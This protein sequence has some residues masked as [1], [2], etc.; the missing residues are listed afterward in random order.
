MVAR[1]QATIQVNDADQGWLQDN[2]KTLGDDFAKKFATLNIEDL[3]NPKGIAD[4][5][6]ELKD[7]LNRDL[8][9]DKV[10]AVLRTDLV[11]QDQG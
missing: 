1:V 7:L 10:E 6:S 8:N 9:T 11:I 3:R 2:K 5:Q 4:A